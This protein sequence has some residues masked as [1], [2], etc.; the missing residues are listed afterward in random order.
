[1]K[2]KIKYECLDMRISCPLTKKEVYVRFVDPEL[3]NIYYNRGYDFIFEEEIEII[4][5]EIT[6]DEPEIE[7]NIFFDE[8]VKKTKND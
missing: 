3:Y 8:I 6:I 1:M 7:E 5:P 2:L 4:E